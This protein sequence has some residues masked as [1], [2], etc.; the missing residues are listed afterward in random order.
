MADIWDISHGSDKKLIQNEHKEISKRSTHTLSFGGGIDFKNSSSEIIGSRK[1]VGSSSD[2]V[3]VGLQMSSFWMPSVSLCPHCGVH[4]L[5]LPAVCNGTFDR[6]NKERY[7]IKCSGFTTPKERVAG[8]QKMCKFFCWV[9]KEKA[10]HAIFQYPDFLPELLDSSFAGVAVEEIDP[11]GTPSNKRQHCRLD[12]CNAIT[13]RACQLCKMHCLQDPSVHGYPNL[14][15]QLHKAV[16][17][18]ALDLDGLEQMP[19]LA[20]HPPIGIENYQCS[21][22]RAARAKPG[23][24]DQGWGMGLTEHAKQR[25]Q[26]LSEKERA[27]QLMLF[28]KQYED[29]CWINYEQKIHIHHDECLVLRLPDVK[30]CVGLER[31]KCSHMP[32]ISRDSIADQPSLTKTLC[33][34]KGAAIP[35]S[36]SLLLSPVKALTAGAQAIDIDDIDSDGDDNKIILI[37]RP[38]GFTENAC[39]LPAATSRSLANA[40][41]SCTGEN[42][43][44]FMWAVDQHECFIQVEALVG[45]WDI[46]VREVFLE[47]VP[48]ATPWVEAT[49]NQHY[50]IWRGIKN[51]PKCCH[52]KYLHVTLKTIH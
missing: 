37:S 24:G 46:K 23:D 9:A 21:M 50:S 4:N 18:E 12:S 14:M 20:H 49:W 16:V 31:K 52:R 13:H 8:H 17:L 51:N 6:A 2:M 39:T 43:W 15:V 7:Y 5:N 40:A 33:S 32:S 28:Y 19:D 38:P 45:N 3:P 29:G 36:S 30:Q 44:P 27:I 42:G 1:A 48:Q 11:S 41:P 47:V 26:I 35:S 10:E 22:R 25:D 34:T